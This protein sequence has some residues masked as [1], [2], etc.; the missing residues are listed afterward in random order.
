[1]FDSDVPIIVVIAEIVI[2]VCI[3]ATVMIAGFIFG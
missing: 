2:A 3:C 1:M